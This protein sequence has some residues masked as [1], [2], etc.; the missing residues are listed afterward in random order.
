MRI[1]F[2][3]PTAGGWQKTLRRARERRCETLQVFVGAPVQWRSLQPRVLEAA[4]W[5]AAVAEHDIC[6][7]FVHAN[8]LLNLAS[9]DGVLWRRSIRRLARD[10]RHADLLGAAGVVTHLGSPKAGNERP[11]DWCLARIASGVDAALESAQVPALLLL[12]NSAGMGSAAGSRYEQIGDIVGRSAYP[13]RLAVCLDTAHSF[14]AGYAWHQREG[15]EAALAE[16]DAAFGL[17]RLR[18]LHVNDSRVPFASGVDR[19]WHIG[20]G[21]IGSAGFEVILNHPRLRDL[22]MVM[23]TP[24]ASLEADLRNL[25]ALRRCIDPAHRPSLRPPPTD[26]WRPSRRSTTAAPNRSGRRSFVSVSPGSR[27]AVTRRSSSA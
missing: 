9:T 12:E 8:Y 22:P 21:Q 18:L 4:E 2:H 14:A 17:D 16:A 1:G 7:V 20:Q 6:P 11:L 5:R 25:R 24:E 19:H 3:V 26:P 23:E 15:L 10:L 27:P 13:D